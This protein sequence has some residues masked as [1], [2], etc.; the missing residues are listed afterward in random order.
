MTTLDA[1]MAV[2]TLSLRGTALVQRGGRDLLRYAG[3]TTGGD[4][5]LPIEL[6][7]RF[8]LA[9]VSKQFTAAA[10]LLLVDRGRIRLDDRVVDLVG[11]PP[12]WEGIT[13]HH[14]LCHTAGLVH[15]HQFAAAPLLGTPGKQY[16][17][18]SPGY[19]LL[20]HI[21]ERAS[22]AP[23]REFLASEL[24][25]PLKMT[26]TFAGNGTKEPNLAA[27]THE[28]ELV[29]SFEL[30]VVGMGAGDVWSTVDDL[31]RWDQALLDGRILSSASRARMF[32]PQ[33]PV[34]ERRLE[35]VE[36]YGYGYG[37]YLGDVLG[38]RA[39]FHPGDNA[40]FEAINVLLPDDDARFIALT[41]DSSTDILALALQ[42]LA[43]AVGEE[44]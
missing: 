36:F 15:W 18:S 32:E 39:V 27:P 3:G 33:A 16:A 4:P 28:G 11:G 34:T 2:E 38:H 24:F 1:D 19:V 26:D 9:S 5:D 41:N 8:Q 25:E 10:T 44:R 31:S 7:T 37:W 40:G 30:D 35:G 22:G 13:V 43:I 29:P 17:Y 20:A 21:V 42:L 23:Y 14:L 12:A 6:D